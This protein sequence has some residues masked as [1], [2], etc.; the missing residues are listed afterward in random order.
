MK[1]QEQE[2]PSDSR[3]YKV[4]DLINRIV[5]KP[6]VPYPKAYDSKR[7]LFNHARSLAKE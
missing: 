5:Q 7:D 2:K 6:E 3:L 1:F 4:V